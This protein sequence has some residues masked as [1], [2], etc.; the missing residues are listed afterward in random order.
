[1]RNE[2][3][4][5][6][7]LNG[8]ITQ[9]SEVKAGLGIVFGPAVNGGFRSGYWPVT[10][11]GIKFRVYQ[12]LPAALELKEQHR[13]LVDRVRLRLENAL[14]KDGSGRYKYSTLSEFD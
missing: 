8:Q 12:S 2:A 3:I 11:G 14:V 9:D 1:M 4:R 6:A 7:L 10:I 13:M 5:E